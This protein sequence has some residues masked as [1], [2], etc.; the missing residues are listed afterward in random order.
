MI[1]SVN[2]LGK[3]LK[4][5]TRLYKVSPQQ[6]TSSDC[7]VQ[8]MEKADCDGERPECKFDEQDANFICSMK[9][10]VSNSTLLVYNS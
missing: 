9:K 10:E 1:S 2:V 6:Q 4:V 3:G 8:L 7:N 5:R